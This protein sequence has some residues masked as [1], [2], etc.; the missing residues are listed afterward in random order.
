MNPL[1]GMMN[2]NNQN[3][4]PFLQ[5]LNEFKNSFNG[6]PNQKIQE[7]LNSGQITQEQ[8]NR[9]VVQAEQIRKTLGI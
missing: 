3:V 8:Y 9:A 7:M 2:G 4:N 6:D 5:R 1:Y